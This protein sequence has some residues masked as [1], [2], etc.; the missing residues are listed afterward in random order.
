MMRNVIAACLLTSFLYVPAAMSDEPYHKRGNWLSEHGKQ[1]GRPSANCNDC[2]KSSWCADCHNIKQDLPPSVRNPEKVEREYVHRADYRSRHSFEAQ[3]DQSWCI[4]C[5]TVKSCQDCHKRE[6]LQQ[7]VANYPHP[8]G[9]MTAASP[10]FHANSARQDIVTCA[11]CHENGSAT[12]CITC[13]STAAT[14][15]SPH[16]NGWKTDLN[17]GSPMCRNCH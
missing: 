11:S 15:I 6:G 1:A 7:G 4:R 14:A 12:N 3:T 10:N 5:H 2:H 9:W 17:I 16:P 13:H 8:A